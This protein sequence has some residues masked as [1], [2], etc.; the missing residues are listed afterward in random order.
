MTLDG[1]PVSYLSWSRV[2]RGRFC[3]WR[4][5]WPDSCQFDILH[6]WVLG[7]LMTQHTT[8]TCHHLTCQDDW[9]KIFRSVWKTF[10]SYTWVARSSCGWRTSLE[11][12]LVQCDCLHTPRTSPHIIGQVARRGRTSCR[13]GGTIGRGS[14]GAGHS[15]GHAHLAVL[16]TVTVTVSHSRHRIGVTALALDPA[17]LAVA[18]SHP[19]GV[20]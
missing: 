11:G 16:Q 12:H 8:D 4:Q 5:V 18:P 3:G 9:S 2:I 6:H 14:Q 10:T 13:G 1:G 15:W 7:V 19:S 17:P 20:W